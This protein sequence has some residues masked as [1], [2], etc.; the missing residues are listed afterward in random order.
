MTDET[1]KFTADEQSS[2]LRF[3]KICTDIRQC[4]FVNDLRKQKNTIDFQKLPDGRWKTEYPDYDRDDFRAFLTHY[5]K[6][7][8]TGEDTNIFRVLKILGRRE[9]DSERIV[10]KEIRKR[11]SSEGRVSPIKIAIGVPGEERRFSPED[12]QNVLFNGDVFHSAAELQEDL[13]RINDFDIFTKM[14]FLRYATI[15]IN[16][17]C[18]IANVITTRGYVNG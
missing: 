3:L 5:R 17:A 10:L 12:I 13:K 16:Q 15:V 1:S 9:D 11:L 8:A 14:V 4:R 7:V 2:F 18:Q 6:L